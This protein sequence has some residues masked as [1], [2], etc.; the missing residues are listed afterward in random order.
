MKCWDGGSS[1]STA[2]TQNSNLVGDVNVEY[3]ISDDGRFR[4]KM[5]NEA[6]DYN[7]ANANQSPYTQGIGVFYREEFDTFHQFFQN[8]F[9]RKKNR[10]E[11]ENH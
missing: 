2:A 11:K 1:A 4:A 7:L 9:R 3:K 5:F 10:S 8:M 6:N